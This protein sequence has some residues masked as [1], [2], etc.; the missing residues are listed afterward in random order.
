MREM[1]VGGGMIEYVF[2][3]LTDAALIDAVGEATRAES[4]AVARRYGLIGALDARRARDLEE[5]IFWRTDPYE[6]VSA[7]IAA[8]ENISRGRACNE[9]HYARM[10]RDRLPQ[11]AAVFG[12]G[13]IDERMVSIIIART[14]NVEAELMAQVDGALA[15][16]CPKWMRL[17]GPKLVDR[18][19]VWVA[20]FDPAAVRVPPTVDDNRHVVV[21]PTSAGM[22]GIWANI[23]APDAAAFDTRLD[24]LAA[25]V[26]EQD[27]RSIDQRR[28]DACGALGRGEARLACECGAGDCPVAAER[29]AA[30]DVVIHVLAEAATVDGSSDQPGY[31]AGFG[32][33]PAE[34]VRALAPSAQLKPVVLPAGGP[35]SGVSALGGHRGVCPVAG[36]DVSLAGL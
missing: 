22:A 6:E 36:S 31:L 35:R 4:A 24:A 23:H 11:V 28:A 14:E 15:A 34:S 13:V 21:G 7:E 30:A 18:L 26:C 1:S 17:S 16:H 29:K 3:S 27:P 5:S 32:V 2:E 33:L 10:L 9:V 19:D 12:T 8:A 20:K 25:G